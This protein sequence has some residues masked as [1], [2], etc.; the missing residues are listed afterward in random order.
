MH[1]SRHPLSKMALGLAAITLAA[2][3]LVACGDD[4]TDSADDGSTGGSSEVTVSD[5]WARP[6]ADLAA[7]N[8]SAIYMTIE[9]G[10]DDDALMSAS[11]PDD[12]AGEAQI[13]ETMS[14]DG[15]MEGMD[16]EMDGEMDRDA[17]ESGGA[18]DGSEP[19]T[20]VGGGMMQMQEVD[21]I[22]V[23]SGETV[24]LKPGG[25]H[26]M[27]LN[28]KRPLIPGESID[29]TLTFEVAGEVTTTA[30]VREP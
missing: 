2:T 11:V 14:A 7:S 18:A 19:T 16:G 25:Y 28:V 26:V 20:T 22:A 1:M 9:G 3:A 10:T 6:V 13:H 24:E 17:M 21:S 27:L 5:A 15:D 8:R 23:P 12:I 29:V 4:P 30:E